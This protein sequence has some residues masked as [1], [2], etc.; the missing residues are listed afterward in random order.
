EAEEVAAAPGSFLDRLRAMGKVDR[1]LEE[2]A[3]LFRVRRVDAPDAA[4]I[5]PDQAYFLRENLRLRLLNARLALLSRNDPLFRGDI[6]QSVKWIERYFDRSS[7]E[8]ERALVQL[9]QLAR[10]RTAGEAPSVTDSLGAV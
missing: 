10:A 4:L 1:M 3:S 6:E 5:A 9:E 7:P 2:V 8:I